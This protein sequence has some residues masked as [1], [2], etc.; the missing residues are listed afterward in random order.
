MVLAWF[1]TA[2]VTD[3]VREAAE[4]A[5]QIASGDLDRRMQV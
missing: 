3:P 1:V 4:I 2:R 5:V